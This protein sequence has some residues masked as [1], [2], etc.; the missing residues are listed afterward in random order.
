MIVIVTT[1]KCVGLP[2]PVWEMTGD[3]GTWSLRGRWVREVRFSLG[4]NAIRPPS[5]A[6]VSPGKWI[7]DMWRSFV[8]Q[9]DFQPTSGGGQ[10]YMCGR[11]VLSCRK[12][13]RTEYGW[14]KFVT[15]LRSEPV[16]F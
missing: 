11:L 12:L 5:K 8:V 4:Y 13:N 3:L 1:N 7:F 16:T 15:P 2:D 6:A 9:G 10:P 14:H